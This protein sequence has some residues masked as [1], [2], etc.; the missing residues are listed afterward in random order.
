M[1]ILSTPDF[2]FGN[3]RVPNLP[4]KAASLTAEMAFVLSQHRGMSGVNY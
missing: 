3:E 2:E 4:G 1:S